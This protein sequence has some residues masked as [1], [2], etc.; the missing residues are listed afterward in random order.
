MIPLKLNRLI[1]GLKDRSII[2]KCERD[3]KTYL[4]LGF[5]FLAFLTVNGSRNDFLGNN[6]IKIDVILFKPLLL[7]VH[8]IKQRKLGKLFLFFSHLSVAFL[9]L[10]I[11]AKNKL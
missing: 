2:E 1:R 9:I 3:F 4:V 6:V 10:V 11:I 5:S 7:F 8:V